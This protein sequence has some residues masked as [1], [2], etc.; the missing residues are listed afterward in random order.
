MPIVITNVITCNLLTRGWP[1]RWTWR[2]AG[3]IAS[4]LRNGHENCF[5][6]TNDK[7]N[8]K[9]AIASRLLHFLAQVESVLGIR[10][11]PQLG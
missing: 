5:V 11:L 6:P 4:K 2:Q 1:S 10:I 9:P 8:E 7:P 3:S